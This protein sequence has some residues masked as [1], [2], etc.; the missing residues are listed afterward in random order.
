[1]KVTIKVVIKQNNWKSSFEKQ[2]E[3]RIIPKYIEY[4]SKTW[5]NVHFFILSTDER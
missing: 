4:T 2:I 1:M 5:D 3:R